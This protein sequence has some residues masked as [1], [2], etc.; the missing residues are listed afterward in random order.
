MRSGAEEDEELPDDADDEVTLLFEE[1]VGVAAVADVTDGFVEVD[2]TVVVEL[3]FESAMLFDEE[4]PLF[5]V[6]EVTE[7]KVEDEEYDC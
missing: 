4:E 1:V 7:P 6:F 3:T 5:V 2:D